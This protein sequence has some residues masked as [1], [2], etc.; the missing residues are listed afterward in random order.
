[1]YSKKAESTIIDIEIV[2]IGI[3]PFGRIQSG[4]IRIRGRVTPVASNLLKLPCYPWLQYLWCSLEQGAISTYYNLDWVPAEEVCSKAGLWLLMLVSCPGSISWHRM[5]HNLPAN[6]YTVPPAK[7]HIFTHGTSPFVTISRLGDQPAQALSSTDESQ[8]DSCADSE[9]VQ[10]EDGPS[11]ARSS[12]RAAQNVKRKIR[13]TTTSSAR[14]ATSA[15]RSKRLKAIEPDA[16]HE[17]G[18]DTDSSSSSPHLDNRDAYGLLLHLLPNS[19]T[20]V[21]VGVWASSVGDGGGT[22]R[23]ENVDIQEVVIV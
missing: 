4:R 14:S 9:R 10:I 13:S 19:N 1:M 5:I 6:L 12:D 23:F 8:E 22:A 17:S 2:P 21:R 16:D 7:C 11:R 20:F 18:T 3:N 15:N